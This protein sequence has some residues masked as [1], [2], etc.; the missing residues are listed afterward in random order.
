MGIPCL[1][2]RLGAISLPW[3]ATRPHWQSEK[4]QC[5]Y[6]KDDFTRHLSQRDGRLREFGDFEVDWRPA[7]DPAT[8]PARV[9]ENSGPA[10]S[11]ERGNGLV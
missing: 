11:S 2:S 8:H 9:A 5:A 1:L 10:K 3:T 4:S 7:A 6:C